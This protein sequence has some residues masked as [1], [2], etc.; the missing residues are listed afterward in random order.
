MKRGS[1]EVL[2]SPSLF[3]LAVLALSACQFTVWSVLPWC[4]KKQ[5]DFS[6]TGLPP[7]ISV[8]SDWWSVFTVGI[9]QS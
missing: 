4:E 2:I 1:P 5:L 6:L 9:F 7:L 3:E 8:L